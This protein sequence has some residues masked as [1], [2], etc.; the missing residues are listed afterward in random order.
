VISH[1]IDKGLHDAFD[2]PGT[3]DFTAWLALPDAIAFHR[4]QDSDALR[5]H[6][7]ALAAAM[8]AE[9]I[10][11]WGTEP[12]VDPGLRGSMATIRLPLPGATQPE[13]LAVHDRLIDDYGV[14]VPVT[15]LG[16]ALWC[17]ISAQIYNEPDDYRRLIAAVQAL[18]A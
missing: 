8:A 18:R 6:N 2:W 7:R 17:R 9:L 13:A 14:E 4:A 1:G 3:R 12:A 15:A 10:T 16:G 5:A 11:A